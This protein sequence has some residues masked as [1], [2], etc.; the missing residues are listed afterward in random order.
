M[1]VSS[2]FDEINMAH[3]RVTAAHTTPCWMWLEFLSIPEAGE[4]IR[5]GHGGHSHDVL[6]DGT[7]VCQGTPQLVFMVATQNPSRGVRRHGSAGTGHEQTGFRCRSCGITTLSSKRS[8]WSPKR[9]ATWRGT[10]ARTR[11][12]RTP[13]S[14]NMLQEFERHAGMWSM[15][16]AVGC[17]VNHFHSD[18]RGVVERVFEAQTDNIYGE[19]VNGAT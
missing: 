3:S 12:I 7:I 11:E 17:M 6:D 13:C 10:F 9:F 4:I 16:A 15:E 2:W 18:E 1:A 8:W 14:T 5:A 19:L